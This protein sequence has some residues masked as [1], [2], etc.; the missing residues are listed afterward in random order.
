MVTIN[1]DKELCIG[2]GICVDI[3]SYEAIQLTNNR[4]EY[5][6][7]EECFS[8]GHCQAVC[9]VDAVSMDG[10]VSDLNFSTFNELPDVVQP[11]TG[12]TSELV[13]F[14]RSRRS[15]RRYQAKTVPLNLLEDL[16]KIGTTAP[17]GTNSQLWG[18]SILPER[19]NVLKL[20]DLTAEYYRNLNRQAR[21]GIL[22]LYVKLFGGDRLGRYYRRYHD[23]VAKALCEWDE[24]GKDRLFHGAVAAILVT[25]RKDA[26]CP[27]EDAL[28]AT[29]NI[30]LAAHV[31]GLGS[32]LI[33]F[34]VEAMRR[35]PDMKRV[36]KIDEGEEIYSVIALG[37]PDV[38]YYRP[39]ARKPVT[40]RILRPGR[41]KI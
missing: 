6:L 18:F 19:G 17:S 14:I 36:M 33:G 39:A 37:Y 8:C 41:D 7:P 10:L 1:F 35:S 16:V 24:E 40:V 20:G 25:G 12:K 26:S 9:P 30:L 28:L 31:M 32:C 38:I 2:C 27:A 13:A 34:V 29:Q 11:G 15:C 22:R 5:I 3:C 4:A 21:N 23:S